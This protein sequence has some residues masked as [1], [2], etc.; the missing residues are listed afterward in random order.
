MIPKVIHYCWFG[1][2]TKPELINKCISS[3][4]KY[5]PDFKI[6]E[7][8]ESNF[9]IH[10]C[11]YIEEAYAEKKWAFVSDYARL[12][13]MAEYGGVYLDTDIE[14]VK[15]L[16]DLINNG[17]YM[18][19]EEFDKSIKLITVN[20]GLGF[21]CEKGSDIILGILAKYDVAHFKDSLGKVS[22]KTIVDFTT[23]LLL[24]RG[25]KYENNIQKINDIYVYP[26]EYFNPINVYS[27]KVEIT[28]KTYSIHHFMASWVDNSKK[29]NRQIYLALE[30]LLGKKLASKIVEILKRKKKS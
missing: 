5:C 22:Y 25:L 19:I 1:G 21:A 23:E 26:K 15:P 3:W 16:S 20:P 4:K 30:K 6:I 17:G 14:I 12:K 29:T 27:K 11:A 9:N 28:E 7:W 8:N 10:S 13:I 18:G 2:S 24:E